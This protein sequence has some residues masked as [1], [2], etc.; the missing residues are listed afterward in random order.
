MS[1]FEYSE[2]NGLA[3]IN[4]LEHLKMIAETDFTGACVCAENN[5]PSLRLYFDTWASHCGSPRSVF[6]GHTIKAIIDID[7][8]LT[9]NDQDG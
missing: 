4:K 6:I 1:E 3:M 5:I 8:Q 7:K 2:E 9:D